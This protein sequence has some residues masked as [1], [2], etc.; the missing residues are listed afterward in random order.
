MLRYATPPSRQARFGGMHIAGV[1]NDEFW[2]SNDESR[3]G[4][5]AEIVD[6]GKSR[7]AQK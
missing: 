7:K 3:Y 2:G 4:G 6:W 5:L 1:R